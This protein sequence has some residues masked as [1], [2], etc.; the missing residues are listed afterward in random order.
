MSKLLSI[1]KFKNGNHVKITGVPKNKKINTYL[2]DQIFLGQI[3]EIEDSDVTVRYQIHVKSEFSFTAHFMARENTTIDKIEGI[4]WDEY[5]SSLFGFTH[6]DDTY[7]FETPDFNYQIRQIA[8]GFE[9][10]FIR[11]EGV[12]TSKELFC[13]TFPKLFVH[14]VQNIF[15]T[16][17]G[18]QTLHDSII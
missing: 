15:F 17:T 4:D 1:S 10:T 7:Y 12:K 16:R 5:Y 9:V 2:P 6:V 3:T 18:G 8:Q 11:I 14:E 13:D